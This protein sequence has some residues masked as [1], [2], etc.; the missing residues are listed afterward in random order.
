MKSIGATILVFIFFNLNRIQAQVVQTSEADVQAESTF[1]EAT[2]NKMIGRYDLA[3]DQYQEI[4][5]KQP[6]NHVVLYELAFAYLNTKKITEALD[7]IKQAVSAQPNSIHYLQLQANIYHAAQDDVAEA[8]VYKRL[9]ALAPYKELYYDKWSSLLMRINR[10]DEAIK[11]LDLLEKEKGIN[12]IT[13]LRKVQILETQNKSKDAEAE[14]IKLNQAF[15][16]ELK[17]LHAL[18]GFYK[19]NLKDNK[20][21]EVYKSILTFAP[22]DE[23]ANLALAASYRQNGQDSKYLESIASLMANPAI[24]LDVKILE[25]IPY[26]QKAISKQDKPLLEVLEQQATI[27]VNKYPNEAKPYAFYGDILNEKGQYRSAL[28]QYKLALSINDRIAAVW[29]QY[30]S[31]SSKFDTPAHFLNE[32]E[33]AFDLFPNH[34]GLALQYAFALYKN[35]QFSAALNLLHQTILMAGEDKTNLEKIYSLKGAAEIMTGQ[36]SLADGSFAKAI[37]INPNSIQSRQMQSYLLATRSIDL[38][39]A[40]TLIQQAIRL[41]PDQFDLEYTQALICIKQKK[42][43]EARSWFEASLKHG[44]SASSLVLE[45]YGDVLAHFKEFDQAVQYWQ[46]ALEL[47]P[48]QTRIKK[49]IVD[50]VVELK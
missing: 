47:N 19:K 21:L 34:T 37:Q 48:E 18:A 28:E 32:S 20:A 26:L 31:L 38:D 17:Y 27:L 50:R 12:E 42:Y 4:L 9:Q 16:N 40:Q 13:S 39:K 30:L 35:E 46:K 7:A 25:L 24:S 29:D 1:I 14:L 43:A 33:K 41:A 45:Q 5:K 11:V 49:K 2:R 44:G 22:E 8:G 23:I 10:F 3:I 36:E 6:G 15:P